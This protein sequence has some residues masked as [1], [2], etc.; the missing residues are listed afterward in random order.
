MSQIGILPRVV[1][2][3]PLREL[4][5]VTPPSRLI[6]FSRIKEPAGTEPVPLQVIHSLFLEAR[7]SR[8]AMCMAFHVAQA[9]AEAYGVRGYR[10]ARRGMVHEFHTAG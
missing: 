9:S 8:N 10:R 6:I 2:G 5:T 3:Q 1:C 4:G 7:T